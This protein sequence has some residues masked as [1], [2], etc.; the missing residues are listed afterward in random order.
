[1]DEIKKNGNLERRYRTVQCVHSGPLIRYDCQN[2]TWPRTVSAIR[3]KS[4][5]EYGQKKKIAEHAITAIGESSNSKQELREIS[6]VA[7]MKTEYYEE[8]KNSVLHTAIGHGQWIS[9][10]SGVQLAWVR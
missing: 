5:K 7:E 10:I 4:F 6:V 9:T 1:M 2:Y 8:N 3:P